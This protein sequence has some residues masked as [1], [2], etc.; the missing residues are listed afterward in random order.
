MPLAGL[1]SG[2][3]LIKLRVRRVRLQITSDQWNKPAYFNYC[4]SLSVLPHP[5]K[6]KLQLELRLSC[7]TIFRS[8]NRDWY[9]PSDALHPPCRMSFRFCG[10]HYD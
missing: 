2:E 6:S 5:E 7:W 9:F 1:A 8:S 4:K 10:T 3:F